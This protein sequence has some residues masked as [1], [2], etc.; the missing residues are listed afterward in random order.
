[1]EGGAAMNIAPDPRLR[2]VFDPIRA[3]LQ[4]DQF[5]ALPLTGNTPR[6]SRAN[7]TAA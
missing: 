2:R 6:L 5:V 3:R 4:T 7:P 1:M